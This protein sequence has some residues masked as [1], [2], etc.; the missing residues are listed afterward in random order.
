ML[1]FDPKKPLYGFTARFPHAKRRIHVFTDER[2]VYFRPKN[3]PED[4]WGTTMESVSR[5]KEFLFMRNRWHRGEQL[6]IPEYAVWRVFF[7]PDPR[8]METRL[9][10]IARCSEGGYVAPVGHPQNLEG[11]YF[12]STEK[13]GAS[14][15][16]T[17]TADL[18]EQFKR[19]WRNPRSDVRA[20]LDW[21]DLPPEERQ[22]RSIV[23]QC[24]GRDEVES[25][26]HAACI[27][28]VKEGWQNGQSLRLGIS[29][30]NPSICPRGVVLGAE[31]WHSGWR[32]SSEDRITRLF[33][34]LE[35]RSFAVVDYPAGARDDAT[36]AWSSDYP[37]DPSYGK[38]EIE[39]QVTPPTQHERLEAALFL[40]G[41]LQ[42]NAPDLLPD[43]FPD[44][45]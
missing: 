23:W 41:W 35:E 2:F 14:L 42:I 4:W 15:I 13:I 38:A 40:R 12:R 30:F 29:V 20:A 16:R 34:R 11:A 24:G 31:A 10:Q 21:P 45:A 3:A 43:W 25:V 5:F 28:E 33:R 7:L 37:L 22:W 6:R 26:A 9:W 18:R 1:P 44:A 8:P 19:E 17:S 36:F 27:M 32:A 39:I